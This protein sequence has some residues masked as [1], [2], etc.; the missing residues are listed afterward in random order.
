MRL[1]LSDNAAEQLGY[2]GKKVKQKRVVTQ[3]ELDRKAE[4]EAA[5]EKKL[6][7]K[8]AKVAA[9]EAALA[10]DANL[11][12]A[13]DAVGVVDQQI[14]KA[15][16]RLAKDREEYNKRVER[17]LSRLLNTQRQLENIHAETQEAQKE[18]ETE[19]KNVPPSIAGMNALTSDRAEK[20]TA[21][22]NSF[23]ICEE[24]FKNPNLTNSAKSKRD[25]GLRR[26]AKGIIT[27]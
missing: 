11:Q 21:L 5:R 15:E 23:N 12:T 4:Q 7:L 16:N 26:T 9:R 19:R 20:V 18:L 24:A 13:L 3:E 8:Q 17:K 22:G 14:Q 2:T 25:K 1:N 10:A 6:L 27:K